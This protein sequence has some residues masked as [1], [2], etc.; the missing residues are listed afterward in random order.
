MPGYRRAMWSV[1]G[2]YPSVYVLVRQI[3]RKYNKNPSYYPSQF[4]IFV[5]YSYKGANKVRP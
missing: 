4:I 5:A 1:K 3:F 2:L